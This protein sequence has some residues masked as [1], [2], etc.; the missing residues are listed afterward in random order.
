MRSLGAFVDPIRRNPQIGI[1]LILLSLVMAGS[2]LVAPILS[3][4]AK[5]FATS[6]TLAGM[7]ITSFGAARLVANYPAG[8][9][10]QQY[11]R[12]RLLILGLVIAAAGSLASALA[13]SIGWLIVWRFVQGTGSGI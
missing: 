11:G 6:T 12:R 5:M 10:S 13:P 4:Y 1:M 7:V 2:G 9:L 3:I 8:A